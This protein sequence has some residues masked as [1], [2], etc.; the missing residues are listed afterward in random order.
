MCPS[1]P[2][3]KKAG[4]VVDRTDLKFRPLSMAR[5]TPVWNN[6]EGKLEVFSSKGFND[7]ILIPHKEY[8]LLCQG[9]K[10]GEVGAELLERVYKVKV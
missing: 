4:F 1:T 7:L 6:S 9:E 10:E 8:I 2:F 3:G 5:C